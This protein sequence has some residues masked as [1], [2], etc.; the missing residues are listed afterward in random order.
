MEALLASG[1]RA[2]RIGGAIAGFPG[3]PGE[4]TVADIRRAAML[5]PAM[6]GALLPTARERVGAAFEHA[7]A[8]HMGDPE[9]FRAHLETEAAAS[10]DRGHTADSRTQTEAAPPHVRIKSEPAAS[11]QG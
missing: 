6:L 2:E 5:R 1:R 9:H 3:P 4:I 11:P 10:P 8:F 7:D